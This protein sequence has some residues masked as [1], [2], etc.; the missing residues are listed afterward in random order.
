[1]HR[2]SPDTRVLIRMIFADLRHWCILP[3]TGGTSFMITLG[4]DPHPGSHTVVALD[5]NGRLLANLTVPNTGAGLGQL[6]LFAKQFGARRWAIEG[7]GNHFI[8]RFVAELLAQEETGYS[9]APS[10]TSQYR[11]RRG[12][13]KNDIVDATN[14]ARALLANPQLP[15]L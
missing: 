4:L 3:F 14:V 11:S 7:A 10:L 9:I 6:H 8:A 1:M 2:W 12:R 13:K 5:S 15:A